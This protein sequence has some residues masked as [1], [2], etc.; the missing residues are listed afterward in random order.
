MRHL[1]I[2]GAGQAWNHSSRSTVS[3]DRPHRVWRGRLRPPSSHVPQSARAFADGGFIRAWK[4]IGVAP[5]LVKAGDSTTC[6]C[7]ANGPLSFLVK[8]RPSLAA[9]GITGRTG[10]A[11][12]APGQPASA[13]DHPT[14]HGE[15]RRCRSC[16]AC[17]RCRGGN[18]FDRV[19][20][21]R[22]RRSRNTQV[23]R[24]Q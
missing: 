21:T 23:W 17:L 22:T 11:W 16:D 1:A 20:Q 15:P 6:A 9:A 2:Y 4:S 8:T 10:A 7:S 12:S 3:V 5:A 14:A 24:R 18:A 13:A 19:R